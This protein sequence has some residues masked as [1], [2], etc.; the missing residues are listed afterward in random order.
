MSEVAKTVLQLQRSL[1]DQATQE[2][3]I[4]L[5]REK[6]TSAMARIS[7]LDA[8]VADL[9]SRVFVLSDKVSSTTQELTA[10]RETVAE[11]QQQLQHREEYWK[12]E[13][14]ATEQVHAEHLESVH[15]E[16]R[17]ALDAMRY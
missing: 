8:T 12:Q 17:K 3:I 7:V 2:N 11:L 9:R 13:W 6:C 1:K 14:E 4:T 10:E 16:H 5:E 15:S